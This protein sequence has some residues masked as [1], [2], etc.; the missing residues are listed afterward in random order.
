MY[1]DWMANFTVV[2]ATLLAITLSVIVHYEGLLLVS[3]NLSPARGPQRIKVLYGILSLIGLHVVEIWIFGVVL[4]L[5]LQ[6]PSCGEIVGGLTQV[7]EVG[8]LDS[9]Y[10]SAM[11]YSTVGF[12]DV[13]PV[14]PI[15]FLAGI[16]G[17]IGL[18]LIG[19]SASFTY[20]EME[21]FWRVR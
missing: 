1:D 13:V 19:W 18:L 12:G 10:F 8:L 17:L 11:T 7:R 5:L 21:R 6:W 2:A 3:R 20:L 15:R 14:G 16:E 4:W 9:I